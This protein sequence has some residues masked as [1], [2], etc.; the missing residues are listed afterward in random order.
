MGDRRRNHQSCSTGRSFHHE[1]SAPF[2]ET[3]RDRY[4]DLI[5][6]GDRVLRSNGQAR[7]SDDGQLRSDTSGDRQQRCVPSIRFGI[8]IQ[9]GDGQYGRIPNADSTR[10]GKGGRATSSLITRSSSDMSSA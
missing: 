4:A 7:L 10:V 9:G 3:R 6:E 8:A 1:R 2:A 5:S